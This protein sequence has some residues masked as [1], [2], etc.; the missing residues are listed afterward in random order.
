VLR[1][2][3]G[4]KRD[5]IRGELRRLHNEELNDLYSPPNII[6][7]ITL[8]RMRWMCH[9]ARM[10]RGEV[11][12]GSLWGNVMDR[13]HLEDAGVDGSIKLRWIFRKYY[14][15][16]DWI[17]QAQDRD[18]WRALVNAVMNLWGP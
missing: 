17:H 9:V 11:H 3:F 12:T 6:R 16:M 8:R 7:V 1:G 4:P 15:D 5:E 13:D 18:S 14:G 10:G 2:I